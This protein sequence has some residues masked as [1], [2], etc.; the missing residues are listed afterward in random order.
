VRLRRAK[1]PARTDPEVDLAPTAYSSR[2]KPSM[3]RQ[4]VPQSPTITRWTHLG[5]VTITRGRVDD[6][7]GRLHATPR[8]PSGYYSQSGTESRSA[9][10]ARNRFIVW[11]EQSSHG[12]R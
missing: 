6:M 10:W 3:A 7:G 2:A 12:A 8:R 5:M 1:S 4:T 11:A 9:S